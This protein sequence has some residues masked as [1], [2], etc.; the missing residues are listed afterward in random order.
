METE[1]QL[2]T[3]SAA[4][5]ANNLIQFTNN[6]SESEH[7]EPIMGPPKKAPQRKKATCKNEANE[8]EY[9]LGNAKNFYIL[10]GS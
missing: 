7:E 3:R 9:Q 2:Q 10:K 6:A 8:I 5:V 1:E 4:A